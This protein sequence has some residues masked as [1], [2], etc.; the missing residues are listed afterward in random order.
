LADAAVDDSH[1]AV[2]SCQH[3]RPMG[4]LTGHNVVADLIGE[5]MLPLQI[6]WYTTI[7]DL[8]AWGAVLHRGLGPPGGGNCGE[9]QADEDVDQP[10]TDLSAALT[11]PRGNPRRSRPHNPGTAAE[12]RRGAQLDW[13]DGQRSEEQTMWMP[14]WS[15]RHRDQPA[16]PG[17]FSWPRSPAAA[18]PRRPSPIPRCRLFQSAAVKST[19][20]P[21]KS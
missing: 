2:M 21:L 18:R 3:A 12:I 9:G 7:L 13:T 14:S 11:Q 16:R 8:G 15:P 19:D 6:G 1:R 20:W 10:Q 17:P 4:R 5:P